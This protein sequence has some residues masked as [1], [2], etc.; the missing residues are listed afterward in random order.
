MRTSFHHQPEAQHPQ[1]SAFY[2]LPADY[3]IY[4]SIASFW[5]CASHVCS[6]PNNRHSNALHNRTKSARSRLGEAVQ[7]VPNQRR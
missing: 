6:Y 3:P 2:K 5:R 4:G 1:S 7:Y